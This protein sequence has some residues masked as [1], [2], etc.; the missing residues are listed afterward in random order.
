MSLVTLPS[1]PSLPTQLTTSLPHLIR[2]FIRPPLQID[3]LAQD[4]QLEAFQKKIEVTYAL[5][6]S[7]S[8]DFLR[9]QKREHKLLESAAQ[10][11]ASGF[12][13]LSSSIEG[14]GSVDTKDLLLNVFT[15][16]N[17][18]ILSERLLYKR[19]ILGLTFKEI[20]FEEDIE[21]RWV[22]DHVNEAIT[23]LRLI[24]KE[25]LEEKK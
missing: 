25:I 20:A 8:Y 7:R 14:S 24:G 13:R 12:V 22:S 17:L 2:H 9:K 10:A 18:S 15:R 3:D 16:A 11:K 21:P 19:F 5:V 4:I 1:L 23:R 6:R